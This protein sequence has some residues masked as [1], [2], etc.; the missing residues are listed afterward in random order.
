MTAKIEQI[1]SAILRKI[2]SPI[3]NPETAKVQ[4]LIDTL[5]DT[6]TKANGVGIAAPQIG[7]SC[8]LFIVASRPNP[9]YPDAPLMQPTPMINPR[10]IAH[11]E[12]KIMGMEGC[13]SV[14]GKRGQVFRYQEITVEYIT[15]AGKLVQQEYTDF[16]ARIIQHELDHLNGIL[17]VDHVQDKLVDVNL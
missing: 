4:I 12:N 10:I 8:R 3:T 16:I 5:I 11:S 17:F 6:A 9:R 13:L 7:E 2:A 1:G 14:P 15:R